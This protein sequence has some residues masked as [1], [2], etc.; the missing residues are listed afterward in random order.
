MQ[1]DRI[2][3]RLLALRGVG[4]IVASVLSIALADAK[5]FKRGRDFAAS[6]GL[7]PRQHST[8]GKNRLLGISK[9]GDS[10]LRKMLVHGARSVL[11]HI[12]NKDDNLS[13]WLRQLSER[14][15]FNIVTIALA[16]KIARAAWAMINN[17]T[18]YDPRLIA[19]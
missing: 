12:A 19:A 10:Y 2:A 3:R 1:K 7:T 15:H 16:N 17:D 18:Q 8:G 5:S 14:K 9:R 13:N 4:P 6:I 11:C